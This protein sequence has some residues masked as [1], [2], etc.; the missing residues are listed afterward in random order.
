MKLHTLLRFSKFQWARERISSKF[1]DNLG[2]HPQKLLP[3][4]GW[5]VGLDWKA[6]FEALEI[7]KQESN[8]D[9]PVVQALVYCIG[10]TVVYRSAVVL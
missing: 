8:R 3:A 6:G 5:Q 4:L 2:T 7:R 9:W 1:T 10:S